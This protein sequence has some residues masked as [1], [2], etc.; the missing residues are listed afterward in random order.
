MYVHITTKGALSFRIA[1]AIRKRV[2]FPITR[3][4]KLPSEARVTM[5]VVVIVMR[6]NRVDHRQPSRQIGLLHPDSHR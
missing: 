5:T 1:P 2:Y 6:G 4:K 3:R